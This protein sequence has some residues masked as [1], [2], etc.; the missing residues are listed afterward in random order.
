MT[1][2]NHKI[3]EIIKESN[4]EV[5]LLFSNLKGDIFCECQKDKQVVSASTIKT[6]I[7]L[8]I[9]EEVRKGTIQL[10]DMIYVNE[11][12]EDTKVFENGPRY[13][14]LYELL[15]WMI[16][17]S[18]NT[19]TNV[20]INYFGMERINQYIQEVLELK[21]TSLQRIMLDFD[22]IKAGKN[23]YISMSD[24]LLMYQKLMNHEI[25][26]EELCKCAIEILTRQRW[27]DDIMRY[28]YEPVW[29]AHKTGSLDYIHLDVGVM[30]IKNEYY[31]IGIS[32][33]NDE[34]DGNQQLMGQ[35]GRM[36]YDAIIQGE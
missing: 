15:V 21:S 1:S 8:A 29:F 22:A 12:L 4:N 7:M 32:V 16:I 14:S 9:L 34:I 2:L 18:D 33:K 27:K 17:L 36:I 26:N 24:M 13:A 10:N 6:P 19:S 35:L 23:N 30:C 20:L 5:S 28:I 11:V 3:N 31:F 25:L